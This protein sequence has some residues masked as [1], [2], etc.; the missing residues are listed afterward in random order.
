MKNWKRSAVK[1]ALLAAALSGHAA[2]GQSTQ[3]RTN[4]VQGSPGSVTR[5]DAYPG[6]IAAC[7][8]AAAELAAVRDLITALERENVLLK[9]RLETEIRTASKL[10]DLDGARR[11]ESAALRDALAAR[12]ETILAKDGVIASQEKLIAALQK[13]KSSPWKRLGDILIGVAA[14]AVLR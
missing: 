8:A 7:S 3:T 1:L 9:A 2:F 5:A 14:G 13:R 4:S 6:S 12:S 11:A 10:G